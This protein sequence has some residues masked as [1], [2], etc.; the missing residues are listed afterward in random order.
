METKTPAVTAVRTLGQGG[1]GWSVFTLANYF[2]HW[3]PPAN[4]QIAIVVLVIGGFT[5]IQ[6]WTEHRAARKSAEEK[7][8]S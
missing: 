5:Y 7:S 3:D 6:N 8:N 4:V 1:F 2:S